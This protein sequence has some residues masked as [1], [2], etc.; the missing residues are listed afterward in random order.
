MVDASF[1]LEQWKSGRIG[2]HAN[3]AHPCLSQHWSSIATSGDIRVFV[4]LCGKS[5]DLD[6]L[7]ARGCQ[8]IG[9]ELSPLAIEQYLTE[10]GL[11]AVTTEMEGML[12][13]DSHG[14]RLIE[15]DFF[16]LSQAALDPIDAV[17][18]RAALI[19]IPPAM[20]PG[21]ASHLLSLTRDTAPI[22]LI[23]LDYDPAEMQ[24]PPFATPP[25]QVSRL[26]GE[27]YRIELLEEIDALADNPSLQSRGLTTL[28]ES[29]WRLIPR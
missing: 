19:A 28:T 27:R 8:V 22:L 21:Y 10:H 20:Q 23:T 24:G 2:F 1:W 17:Y 11:T 29:A 9:V 16:Q 4:P 15:G 26:F 14:L 7:L 5:L 3:A 25:E 13:H 12:I 6:F 18:D